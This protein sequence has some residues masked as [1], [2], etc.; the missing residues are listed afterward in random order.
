MDSRDVFEL[1][2]DWSLAIRVLWLL[3]DRDEAVMAK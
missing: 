2:I 3:H 1:G